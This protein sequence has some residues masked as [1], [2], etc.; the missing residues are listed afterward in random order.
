MTPSDLA[1]VTTAA[2]RLGHSAAG[3]AFLLAIARCT[4][5]HQSAIARAAL[6]R[7]AA[8]GGH[9][10]VSAQRMLDEADAVPRRVT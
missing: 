9:E 4:D 10:A 6:H 8:E 3:C 2:D 5:R 7:A 1:H